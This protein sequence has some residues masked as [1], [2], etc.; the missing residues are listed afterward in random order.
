[1]TGRRSVALAVVGWVVVA[2]AGAVL[3]WGV[4]S[5][6]GDGVSGD[7][8]ALPS[9]ERSAASRDPSGT[10]D[11]SPPGSPS[12]SSSPPAT[13]TPASP[14]RPV[15]RTWHG[16]AGVVSAECDGAAIRLTLAT[17]T[18]GYAQEVDETGP[19][20]VRVE[21]ETDESRTRVEARCVD[22]IPEFSEDRSGED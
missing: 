9:V 14:T 17:P 16:A 18:S 12:T 10:P 21:F 11:R 19:D 7:L 1:M 15:E 22:G 20:R 8:D 5:R 13:S 4:I 3:V 2:V 6:A